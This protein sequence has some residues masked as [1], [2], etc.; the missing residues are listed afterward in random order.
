VCLTHAR[1]YDGIPALLTVLSEYG[2]PLFVATSKLESI[3][4][5][6]LRHFD[7]RDH[8]AGVHHGSH[9]DA[10]KADVVAHAMAIH[11][12]DPTS[13]V[14]VG[15]RAHDV[16]AARVN[17]IRSIGVLYGYGTQEELETARADELCA[18]VDE[19]LLELLRHC[20]GALAG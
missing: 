3:A 6:V 20:G 15:D 2:A 19:L 5:D 17:G 4:D 10:T 18:S 8:F 14:L 12:L 16:T 9:G 13:T 7:L 1:L 11:R